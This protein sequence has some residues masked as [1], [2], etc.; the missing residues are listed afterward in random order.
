M[1]LAKLHRKNKTDV[2]L[3]NKLFK[4]C[5]QHAHMIVDF[6]LEFAKYTLQTKN[7]HEAYQYLLKK[8]PMIEQKAET[9]TKKTSCEWQP[10]L[11]LEK[12]KLLSIE[13]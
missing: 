1:R 4:E 7:A 6:E 8:L 2:L 9:M 13:L 12:A 3:V 11:V 10:K 5:E